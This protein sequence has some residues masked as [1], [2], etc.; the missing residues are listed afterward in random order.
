LLSHFFSKL[1]WKK[2]LS[3]YGTIARD[4]SGQAIRA[5]GHAIDVSERRKAEAALQQALQAAQAASIAKSRFLSNMSHELRTPLNAILGFSQVM[6][7]SNSLSSDQKEQLKIIN[8]SGEHLLNLINDILSMSKIEA[9]QIALNE[10]RFDLYQLLEDIEQMLKLKAISKDLQLIFERASDIP[11]Y[12]QTD[13]N[14][15]R[16][17]L[18][19]LLGNAIKFTAYGHVTLRV[20]KG[21]VLE[22]NRPKNLRSN[23]YLLFEIEDTGPGIAP[24]E[25]DT[26]FDPFVQTEAG[27][28]S[29]QGTG[30]GLP[31]SRQFVQMMGGDIAVS[32]QLGKGTIFTFGIL[33]I[34]IAE[35]EERSLSTTQQ[36]IALEPNQPA[37]RILVVEDVKEN[38]QLLLKILEPLGFQVREAVNGREAIALWSTWKPHLILMDMRMPVMDG[39][40]ATKEIK[41]LEQQSAVAGENHSSPADSWPTKIIALT[42][43]AFDEDRANI[44]AAGCDDFIHK[45]FREP[46][47]FDKLAQHLG[48]RYIYQEDLPP[49]LPQS[50]TLRKLTSDDL[51]VMPPEWIAQ[52]QQEVLC[53][54]DQLILKL[55][56]QIPES[57]TSLAQAL[58][59][60]VNNFRLDNSS[61]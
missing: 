6:V 42:A 36:V 2:T 28:K 30:L 19:N 49:S 55:I 3:D 54:N 48:V 50:A 46:M 13:E 14:K 16:Q 8:R 56:E 39:Y 7:R 12:V 53:A 23:T 24:D 51:N 20:E 27:R 40:E 25:L 21:R 26:L 45:P 41:T 44:M 4:A 61:C 10:N 60:L 35:A 47:L 52:F 15:L 9:G 37:Y 57:E 38:R 5:V 29:M 11:Q 43:S 33:A 18:I 34:E 59:D 22:K 58:T 31:I 1:Y 17:I 32:T